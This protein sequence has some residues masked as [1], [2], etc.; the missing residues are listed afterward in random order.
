M[1]GISA[2]LSGVLLV[3]V[4]ISIAYVIIGWM[5]TYTKE[6]TEGIGNTSTETIGCSTAKIEILNKFGGIESGT[7]VS[8]TAVIKNAGLTDVYLKEVIGYNVSGGTCSML[9]TS[10]ELLVG[11]VYHAKNLSECNFNITKIEATTYCP[12]IIA[13]WTS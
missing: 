4:T 3:I 13:T 1:K 8:V 11:E 6:S 5:S 2:L 9:S 12:G 7:N 10:K